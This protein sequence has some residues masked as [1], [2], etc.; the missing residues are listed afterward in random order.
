[1]TVPPL[2]RALAAAAASRLGFEGDEAALADAFA[3]EIP[4]LDEADR[5]YRHA[6]VQTLPREVAQAMLSSMGA[7]RNDV[8]AIRART[9]EE[10]EALY[11]RNGRSYGWFDPLDSSMPFAAGLSHA[12]ATRV[13]TIA[14]GGRS[15]VTTLRTRVNAAVARRLLPAQIEALTEAK[16]RRRAD[17]E[18]TLGRV[19]HAIA[20][21]R[22][23]VSADEADRMVD[24]LAQIADGWY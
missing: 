8:E 14:D 6:V 15:E 7:F 11:R 24:R 20:G 21:S 22:V 3:R 2:A 16:R 1:M 10:I 18:R 17:F 4:V 23:Q 19:L 13:A 9:R 5:A 12:D